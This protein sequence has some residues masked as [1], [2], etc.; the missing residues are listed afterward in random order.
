MRSTFVGFAVAVI[1]TACS[2]VDEITSPEFRALREERPVTVH[3]IDT[4]LACGDEI[5]TDVHL[6][7]DLTC[8]GDAL[9]VVA[10]GIQINL[11]GH[12]IAGAGAGVGITV[13]AP[14]DPNG[15]RLA[16]T[17]RGAPGPGENESASTEER[18]GPVRYS[19]DFD[20]PIEEVGQAGEVGIRQTV[21]QSAQVLTAGARIDA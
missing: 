15:S 21:V 9:F 10:D 16:T 1:L 17:R 13:R 5:D 6:Q 7:A 11:N 18:Q 3:V 19:S 2:T 4:E 14:R 8:P 12:V 20:Q